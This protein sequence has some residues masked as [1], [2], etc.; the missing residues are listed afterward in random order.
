MFR[1]TQNL[2]LCA[3]HSPTRRALTRAARVMAAPDATTSDAH[4]VFFIGP[5]KTGT[6]SWC[7]LLQNLGMRT[8]HDA[9]SWSAASR[10]HD[11]SFFSKHDAFCDGDVFDVEWLATAFPRATFIY[12]SRALLPWLM[13][14]FFHA[15]DA[16]HA[17]L[18][19]RVSSLALHNDD[20]TAA[21]W[22]LQRDARLL[23]ARELLSSTRLAVLD[24]AS[25][26]P[27]R[28]LADLRPMLPPSARTRLAGLKQ[29]PHRGERASDRPEQ[30]S[31]HVERRLR[32][33]L[34]RMRASPGAVELSG[35]SW[36]QAM[37]DA[38]PRLHGMGGVSTGQRGNRK[39]A[40]R[41]KAAKA[42]EVM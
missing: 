17:F 18:T 9:A 31:E 21:C 33:V 3:Q 1:W 35:A 20:A 36:T 13:S 25:P 22:V 28:L 11:L 29:L 12:N 16:T 42:A 8:L 39:N 4:K 10:R 26:S 34:R 38:C 7:E 15:Q 14:R 37:V 40:T 27:E 2:K 41:L 32:E 19:G 23:R 24:I 30:S 5:N 6:R